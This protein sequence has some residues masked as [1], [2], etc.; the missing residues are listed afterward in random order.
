M[1]DDGTSSTTAPEF[2]IEED[3]FEFDPQ[4]QITIDQS[5]WAF[6]KEYPDDILAEA[7]KINV[8]AYDLMMPETR[9]TEKELADQKL[10]LTTVTIDLWDNYSSGS[11]ADPVP[12]NEMNVIELVAS[13]VYG[14]PNGVEIL[15]QYNLRQVPFE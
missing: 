12:M 4:S 8:I 5:V 15:D 9:L 3:P 2:V 1:A 11:L 7:N 6:L 13:M 14:T 10:T